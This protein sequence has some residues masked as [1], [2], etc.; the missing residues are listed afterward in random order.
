MRQDNEQT[1]DRSGWAWA[2]RIT[3]LAVLYI[4]SIGPVVAI[5]KSNPGTV[6]TVQAI[7]YPVRWL[8]EHTPLKRPIE[9]Y[10]SFWGF[11]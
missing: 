2:A 3:S 10:A 8:H 5:T 11:D 7:Y 4:L 6:T 1:P 9:V